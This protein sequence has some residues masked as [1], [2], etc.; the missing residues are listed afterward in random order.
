MSI[1]ELPRCPITGTPARRKVQGISAKFVRDMWRY[2][3]GVDVDRFFAGR[4]EVGLYESEC[5]LMF[6]EPR[7]AGDQAFYSE[8][9]AR[10][11]AHGVL[12]AGIDSRVEYLAAARH[13]PPGAAVIDVGC[14]GGEFRRHLRHA[15]FRGLDPFAPADAHESVL[16]ESLE[17]HLQG[18]AGTY[19]V[20]TA[21]QVVEHVTEPRAFV[22]RMADL[23]KPGGLL[24]VVVPL[25]PSP[26]SEIPN[27]LLNAPPHH[28]TWWCKPALAALARELALDPVAIEELPVSPH[29]GPVLWLHRL[30]MVRTDPP[31]NERYFAAQWSWYAG[32][33]LAYALS[34]LAVRLK[35]LPA[36]ARPV[37]VMLV[38]RKRAAARP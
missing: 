15:N 12:N 24:I 11:D 7:T 23:L 5:G 26:L 25:H 31:P 4:D 33:A 21:F 29:Q 37:D 6:F 9:Y 16:R 34:R 36:G 1:A 14:G 22:A 28:L 35:P 20:A 27:W 38:A 3:G 19:D 32:L 10:I 18:N 17:Q 8:F 30:C 13:I 2:A